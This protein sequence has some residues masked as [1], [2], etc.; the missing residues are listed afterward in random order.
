MYAVRALL[1]L[2]EAGLWPGILL[3]LCYWYRPDEIAK[4][5]VL[6]TLIGVFSPV[7]SGVLAFAFD[8]VHTA[9]LAG[10]KWYGVHLLI[11]PE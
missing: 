3:H 2:F 7:I 8:G 9:G 5:V 11:T 6:V 4:R 1:G 10:W